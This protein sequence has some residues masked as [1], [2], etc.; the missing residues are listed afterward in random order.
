MIKDL[1]V[2]I[3]LIKEIINISEGIQKHPLINLCPLISVSLHGLNS[4]FNVTEI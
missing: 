3:K 2:K 4:M 1:T